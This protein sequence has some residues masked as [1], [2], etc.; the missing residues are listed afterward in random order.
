MA[1]EIT[2][3]VKLD[4]AKKTDDTILKIHLKGKN[5]GADAQPL[6]AML[7]SVKNSEG[8]TLEIYPSTS[9]GTT[10]APGDE[11]EGD[12]FYVLKGDTPLT[13]TYEN[14]DTKSKATWTINTIKDAS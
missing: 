2:E 11:A 1:I 7:L 4:K 3:A 12:A 9:L 14:P 5:N 6:D 10:L 8:K 13:L